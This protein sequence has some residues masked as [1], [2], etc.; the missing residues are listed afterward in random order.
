MAIFN[1]TNKEGLSGIKGFVV[2]QTP[3]NHCQSDPEPSDFEL[4]LYH[5]GVND[6]PVDGDTIYKNYVGT[7]KWTSADE[8]LA[9]RMEGNLQPLRVDENGIMDTIC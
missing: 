9:R 7:I 6:L 2:T 8:T 1:L 5:D 3:Y 4:I